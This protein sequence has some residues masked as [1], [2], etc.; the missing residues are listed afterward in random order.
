MESLVVD[1]SLS[2]QSTGS[3]V[4]TAVERN[5]RHGRVLR[6]WVKGTEEQRLRKRLQSPPPQEGRWVVL[7][8]PT[9]PYLERTPF[10]HG[11][12]EDGRDQGPKEIRLKDR[13]TFA[14]VQISWCLFYVT[15]NGKRKGLC[16]SDKGLCSKELETC[17]VLS[18]KG[19]VRRGWVTDRLGR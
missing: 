2:V 16:Q 12:R 10:P 3:S 11:T 9:T 13:T 6:G 8:Q 5:L 1:C 14:T 4:E 15:L 18:V 7:N 19:G 17:K